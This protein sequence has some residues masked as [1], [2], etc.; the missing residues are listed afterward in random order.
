MPTIY[1]N[2]EVGMGSRE[3]DLVGDEP[4]VKATSYTDTGMNSPI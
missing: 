3:Q 1:F 2:R 4:I